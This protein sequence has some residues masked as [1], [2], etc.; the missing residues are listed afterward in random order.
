[1]YEYTLNLTLYIAVKPA[2][3]TVHSGLGRFSSF[4]KSPDETY[5]KTISFKDCIFHLKAFY[6]TLSYMK[7][8]WIWYDAAGKPHLKDNVKVEFV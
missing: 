5:S 7:S 3:I 2:L 6:I 4:Y 8:Y 1:M